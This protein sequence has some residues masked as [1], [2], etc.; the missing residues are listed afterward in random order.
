MTAAA[1][2]TNIRAAHD[3]RDHEPSDGVAYLF[4]L[5]FLREG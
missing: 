2:I 4:L 3:E 1:T 5:P